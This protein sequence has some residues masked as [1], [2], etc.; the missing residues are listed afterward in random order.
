MGRNKE[1]FDFAEA[2]MASWDFGWPMSTRIGISKE[3]STL[4]RTGL[5]VG[6]LLSISRVCTVWRVLFM[7]EDVQV[8]SSDDMY[9]T[10]RARKLM[11]EKKS[12]VVEN[13]SKDFDEVESM[14]LRRQYGYSIEYRDKDMTRAFFAPGAN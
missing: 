2:K 12:F 7:N 5:P 11:E 9:W 6:K 14:S 3:V 1:A 10:F 13:W 4:F 8:L